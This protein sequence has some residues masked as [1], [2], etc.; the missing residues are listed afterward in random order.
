[1]RPARA[2]SHSSESS[3]GR[4]SRVR[5]PEGEKEVR[6][7]KRVVR[8]EEGEGEERRRWRGEWGALKTG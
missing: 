2:V 8:E 6:R 5:S 7:P 3:V 1:M 4:G